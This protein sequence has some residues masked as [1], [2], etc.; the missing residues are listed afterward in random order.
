MTFRSSILA[1]VSLI[2]AA[3]RSPNY[4]HNV[5][6]WTI[7]Q[8]GS[9]EF[10]NIT[11]R[12]GSTVGGTSLFY[13]GVPALG[14]LRYSISDTS[15]TD[16]YGNVYGVGIIAYANGHFGDIGMVNGEIVLGHAP[17]F[18]GAGLVRQSLFLGGDFILD[19]GIGD[20]DHVDN[21]IVQA[22][23]GHASQASGSATVPA[24][25]ITDGAGTS[26][27]DLRLSGSLVHTSKTG[28]PDTWQNPSYNAGWA[29]GPSGGAFQAAQ[30]K[31]NGL[32][33]IRVVGIAHTTSTTPNSVIFNLPTGFRP[34]GN[35]H[36]QGC[37]VNQAGSISAVM[38]EIDTN[39]NVF[40]SPNLAT[41]GSDVMFNLTFPLGNLP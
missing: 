3:I 4:V 29:S 12:G 1:G 7:N 40:I 35:N 36:R 15:G 2:R 20:V 32:D 21:T 18:T 25:I 33:E 5:S 30:Y 27:V 14:N 10:N 17:N 19:T 16:A 24:V 37:I 22:L 39:G 41:S 6:G 38:A 34:L 8:D 13:A 31:N 26:V 28:T 23:A 11:I 9:A